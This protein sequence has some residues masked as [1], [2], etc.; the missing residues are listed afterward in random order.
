MAEGMAALSKVKI[1]EPGGTNGSC[2]KTMR[3]LPGSV[4]I[5]G[6]TGEVKFIT[7]FGGFVLLT[8]AVKWTETSDLGNA[9][10]ITMQSAALSIPGGIP[11]PTTLTLLATSI[12]ML[13]RRRK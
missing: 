8:C 7:K 3:S 5:I 11:E 9:D 2:V 10:N 4:A 1:C 6:F 12:M 13:T